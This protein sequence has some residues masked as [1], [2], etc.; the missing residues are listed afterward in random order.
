MFSIKIDGF[1]LF[2]FLILVFGFIYL[3][4]LFILAKI[5]EP[6]GNWSVVPIFTIGVIDALE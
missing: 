1:V 2:V 3:L 6:L 4:S 5:F